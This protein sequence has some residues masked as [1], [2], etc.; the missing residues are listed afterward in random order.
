[1]VTSKCH[2]ELLPGL[3][4]AETSSMAAFAAVTF[5]PLACKTCALL[6]VRPGVVHTQ[7]TLLLLLA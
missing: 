5:R 2:C 6:Q 1:V 7:S 3:L 4:V